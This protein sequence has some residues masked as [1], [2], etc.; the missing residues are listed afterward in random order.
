[1]D[2]G[3]I[4]LAI[5]GVVKG[6]FV[7]F[8]TH[9]GPMDVI[10]ALSI[11]GIVVAVWV[12]SDGKRYRRG[13]YQSGRF[14]SENEKV[15]FWALSRAAGNRYHLFAQV[16]LADLV[17]VNQR[18]EQFKQREAF[19]KVAAKSVDFILCSRQTLEP[20]A[21]IE[22]DDPSHLRSDRQERDRFVN[23]VFKEVGM[24]LLRVRAAHRYDAEKIRSELKYLGVPLG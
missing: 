3:T 22:V 4:I 12:L 21:A 7:D 16:R 19:N 13:A 18:I 11:A 10:W 24:P 9:S 14:L 5:T 6:V 8:L 17:G 15:F 20:V 23:A 1:M 2:A